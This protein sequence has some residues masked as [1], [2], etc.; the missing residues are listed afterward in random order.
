MADEG[1]ST[2]V[3]EHPIDHSI[4][5]DYGFKWS[6]RIMFL[7][8][9]KEKIVLIHPSPADTRDILRN[10]KLFCT[11]NSKMSMRSDR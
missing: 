1:Y 9:K 8:D 4:W 7:L 2:T 5:N 11:K 6:G 10:G 3:I